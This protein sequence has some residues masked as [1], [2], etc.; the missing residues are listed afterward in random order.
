M[1]VGEDI[2]AGM[3]PYKPAN[4]RKKL[5]LYTET[6]LNVKPPSGLSIIVLGVVEAMAGG[7]MP[8]GCE[9]PEDGDMSKLAEECQISPLQRVFKD[10]AN[11]E[12]KENFDMA[13]PLGGPNLCFAK[14]CGSKPEGYP[15]D[16]EKTFRFMTIGIDFC[17][18]LSP[19]NL[20]LEA[21]V[22]V[23]AEFDLPNGED[24]YGRP[25]APLVA[26][27]SVRLAITLTTT[28]IELE[29]QAMMKL[30]GNNQLWVR[31]FGMPNLG[32]IFPVGFGIGISWTFGAPSP[33]PMYFELEFGF[34]GC[35]SPVIEKD[36]GARLGGPGDEG[37][38]LTRA[39]PPAPPGAAP[40]A[41]ARLGDDQMTLDK[42]IAPYACSS[43]DA[44]G[45]KVGWCILT[46]G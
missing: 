40:A 3:L 37:A 22:E 36:S 4:L 27:A 34:M 11:K 29:V 31:P 46:P 16:E 1:A 9:V 41:A 39:L 17:S 25:N 5:T 23:S 6:N 44:Y 10:C 33:V 7:A 13:I 18:S 8:E 24:K 38:M 12:Q 20:K 43:Y 15:V 30:K 35:A 28:A 21:A 45:P 32:I 26:V 19:T 14:T 2:P 42:M